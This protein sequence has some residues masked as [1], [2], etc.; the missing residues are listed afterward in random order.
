MNTE[1]IRKAAQAASELA[2]TLKA[3]CESGSEDVQ[4][5]T[6]VRTR[7]QVANDLRTLSVAARAAGQ[8]DAYGHEGWE[9]KNHALFLHG[10]LLGFD[11][12]LQAG[13]DLEHLQAAW[14]DAISPKVLAQ[15]HNPVGWLFRMTH[16]IV[17]GREVENLAGVCHAVRFGAQAWRDFLAGAHRLGLGGKP[18]QDHA[19]RILAGVAVLNQFQYRPP[20]CLGWTQE[21]L[22]DANVRLGLAVMAYGQEPVGRLP[23]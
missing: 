3:L 23:D 20:A 9:A 22:A 12:R 4:P 7:A 21:E 11:S 10:V 15:K 2:E 14:I 8:N 5:P 18:C 16:E 17:N 1:Y 13:D 19:A 6:L